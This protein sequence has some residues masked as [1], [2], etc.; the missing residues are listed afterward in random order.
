M[1]VADL[2]LRYVEAVVWPVVTLVVAWCLRDYLREAFARMTRI[3]TPAGAIEFEAEARQLRELAEQ[4]DR[5]T[6]DAQT[7]PPGPA[8]YGIPPA[9]W[10]YQ[11]PPPAGDSYQQAPSPAYPS[12]YQQPLPPGGSYPPRQPPAPRPSPGPGHDGA[13]R[14]EP[15]QETVPVPV[16]AAD[17]TGYGSP[18]YPQ[19]SPP[20]AGEL[21]AAADFRDSWAIV[22][23]SPVG[24]LA[25]AWAALS[26]GLDAVLPRLPDPR[27]DRGSPALLRQRLDLAGVAPGALAVYDGLRRLR[28]AAVDDG[29]PVSASAARH[30]LAGCE[31]V[32][33]QV[34]R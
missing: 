26:A 28:D 32:L 27:A 30:F 8:P 20:T 3:E 16:P 7:P 9:T 33:G 25:A 4:M 21:P 10:P 34:R 5:Q 31:R 17:T 24:A 14:R 18:R 1:D 12:P 23:A 11:Q 6:P 22:D 2:V 19:P 13:S 29:A 15:A